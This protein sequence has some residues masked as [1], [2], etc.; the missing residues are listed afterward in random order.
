[1]CATTRNEM[2]RRCG[3][4]PSQW[5]LGRESKHP[6]LLRDIGE[7]SNLASQSQVLTERDFAER[8]RVQEEA[9]KAFI[10]EHAKDTWRRAIVGKSRPMRGPYT[11]GQLVYMFRWRSRGLLSTRHGVWLGPGR[12]IGTESFS[13]SVTPRVLWVAWSG[14]LYKCSPETL[15]P[16]P[17]DEMQFRHL[18]KELCEGR[19]QPDIEEAEATLDSKAGQYVDLYEDAPDD[20][21]FQLSD[22]NQENDD[23]D[24]TQPPPKARRRVDR[25]EA[26]WK[27]RSHGAPP[28]GSIQELPE[29]MEDRW[30]TKRVAEPSQEVQEPPNQ[31]R[32]IDTQESPSAEYTPSVAPPED[33]PMD[34]QPQDTPIPDSSAGPAEVDQPEPAMPPSSMGVEPSA[35]DVP[36]PD[37]D[38]QFCVTESQTHSLCDAFACE[39]SLDVRPEDITDTPMCLWPMLE[40]CCHVE[41]PRAKQRRVEVSF[42]KL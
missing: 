17:E 16:V 22:E 37:E 8:V 41:V 32:R 13:D 7:Q 12:I 36:V 20:E 23:S 39:I 21:D 33:Q 34:E 19:L 18:A 4:L 14:Y 10:E 27:S 5:F 38:E 29:N 24:D 35:V 30:G 15:R 40:E 11:V 28:L 31:S 42:R 9:A 26:Y 2:L 1:M 3:F 6:G 25:S